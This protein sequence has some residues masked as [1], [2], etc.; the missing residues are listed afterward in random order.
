MRNVPNHAQCALGVQHKFARTQ[1][2]N[3]NMHT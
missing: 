2:G 3:A 1:N